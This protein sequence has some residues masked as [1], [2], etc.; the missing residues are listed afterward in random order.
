MKNLHTD[1]ADILGTAQTYRNWNSASASWA[2]ERVYAYGRWT[3]TL[4]E[5][6]WKSIDARKRGESAAS[7]QV[8]RPNCNY[9][10]RANA[11]AT[12]S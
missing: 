7:T 2:K 9:A 8:S 1:W 11:P 4:R 10:Q 5:M 3:F 6:P 12:P